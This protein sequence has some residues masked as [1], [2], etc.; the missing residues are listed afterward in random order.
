MKN[1]IFIW[2]SKSKALIINK[3]LNNYKKELNI[4]FLNIKGSKK[5]S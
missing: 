2:G 5:I 3:V 4:N 1:N